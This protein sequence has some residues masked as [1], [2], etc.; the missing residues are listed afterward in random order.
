MDLNVTWPAALKEWMTKFNIVNINIELARPEC[1]MPFGAYQKLLVAVL[2]PFFILTC[3]G[4]FAGI[5][6]ALAKV[7]Y[8]TEEEFMRVH[9][10]RGIRSFISEQLLTIWVAC[11]E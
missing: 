8:K 11:C 7:L 10:G 3:L 6:F 9:A 1:S 4:L 5:K 2:L